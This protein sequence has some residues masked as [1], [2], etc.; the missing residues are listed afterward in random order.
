M[1]VL[2]V[3][4]IGRGIF[5][6]TLSYFSGSKN[7]TIG[8]LILVPIGKRLV[9]AILESV[10]DIQESKSS[11]KL[12]TYVLGRI[13]KNERGLEVKTLLKIIHGLDM[14]PAKFFKDLS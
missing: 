13:E 4:P 14:T 3:I 12:A 7:L 10:R 11:I 9:P 5:A 2:D 8:S 6:E 1:K